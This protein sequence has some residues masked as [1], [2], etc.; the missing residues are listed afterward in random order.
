M[1]IQYQAVKEEVLLPTEEV[2][3]S[4]SEKSHCCCCLGRRM[5]QV[6]LDSKQ[7]EVRVLLLEDSCSRVESE[8]QRDLHV[9]LE[10]RSES[11][12]GE[13]LCWMKGEM[14][15]EGGLCLMRLMM[16]FLGEKVSV[17]SFLSFLYLP[18]LEA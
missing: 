9:R 2:E 8:I 6:Y 18:L 17:L 11:E 7:E 12:Q 5:R 13:Q 4:V 3:A 1:L 14:E 16:P 10:G 15:V